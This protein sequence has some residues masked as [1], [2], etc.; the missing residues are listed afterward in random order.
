M[1]MNNPAGTRKSGKARVFFAL[2]PDTVVRQQLHALSRQYRKTCG[3]RTM[4]EETLHLTLLFLGEVERTRLDELKKAAGALRVPPFT[5]R[6]QQ[7]AVW[8]HNRICYVAPV[9]A[10]PEL[11]QLAEA[12]RLAMGGAGF[13]F[14]HRGFAPHVTLLRN[15]EKGIEAQPISPIA[16]QVQGYS[17]VESGIAPQGAGYRT[18]QFWGCGS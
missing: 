10:V 14:D 4:R 11:E 12:L 7:V 15:V 5:F 13:P 2:W 3:G 9:D 8:R 1:Q 17:L 6:L 16:W 18:L